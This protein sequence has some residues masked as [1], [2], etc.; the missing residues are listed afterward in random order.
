MTSPY[1]FLLQIAT[2]QGKRVPT[3][4]AAYALQLV[5]ANGAVLQ[6]TSRPVMDG[7]LA[8][9]S[10]TQG[11]ETLGSVEVRAQRA[12]LDGES[13]ALEELSSALSPRTGLARM[14]REALAT[15]HRVVRL[16]RR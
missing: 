12:E 11:V 2:L 5:L 9:A 10:L 13:A 4:V 8:T 3:S 16:A 14:V 7:W 6:V 1:R 15:R